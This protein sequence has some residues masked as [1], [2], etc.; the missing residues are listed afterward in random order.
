MLWR[1]L[2][3]NSFMIYDLSL[4]MTK[5]GV[6]R[7]LQIQINS[8]FNDV[9]VM[10]L[11]EFCA[12]LSWPSISWR[13]DTDI[14]VQSSYAS[15]NPT[16]ASS[17][18]AQ[19]YKDIFNATL[20][21]LSKVW[22]FLS[23]IFNQQNMRSNLFVSWES[24][25]KV[26]PKAKTTGSRCLIEEYEEVFLDEDED[27]EVELVVQGRTIVVSERKLCIH[28]HYF[29]TVHCKP[30]CQSFEPTLQYIYVQAGVQWFRRGW[31]GDHR[32]QT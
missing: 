11:R 10:I 14:E 8:T 15:T 30:R 9:K 17:N 13:G 23:G 24:E 7:F 32:T 26:N 27:D 6:F 20:F 16:Q 1:W 18:M 5:I 31:P 25:L 28:S 22:H 3:D 12:K 21:L 19:Q 2:V 29:R 4:I